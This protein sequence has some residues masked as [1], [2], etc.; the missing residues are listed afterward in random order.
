MLDEQQR[1]PA[2]HDSCPV[3]ILHDVCGVP[4]TML[5]ALSRFK[6]ALPGQSDVS[7]MKP[8]Q[9]MSVD[10]SDDEGSSACTLQ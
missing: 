9:S 2:L 7:G 10:E 3:C 8:R 6:V 1:G 4:P 5:F